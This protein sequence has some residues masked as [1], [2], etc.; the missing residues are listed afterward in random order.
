MT[1]TSVFAPCHMSLMG[2][3][4]L[5]GREFPVLY[6]NTCLMEA[7]FTCGSRH[8]F[9]PSVSV[10]SPCRSWLLKAWV[11]SGEVF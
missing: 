4:R 11:R 9:C 7:C 10:I 2:G 8:D 3:G 6:H 5:G 1:L